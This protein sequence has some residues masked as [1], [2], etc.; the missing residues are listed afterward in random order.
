MDNHSM[1]LGAWIYLKAYCKANG[2][3]RC[4]QAVFRANQGGG[5]ARPGEVSRLAP[6]SKAGVE[7]PTAGLSLEAEG[8]LPGPD[9]E[10]CFRRGACARCSLD[11]PAAGLNIGGVVSDGGGG[12]QGGS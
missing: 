6:A 9:L 11:G 4:F 2:P 12:G 3:G 7:R 8:S 5:G 1:T 10:F